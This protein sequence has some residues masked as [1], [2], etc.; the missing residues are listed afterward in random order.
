[1]EPNDAVHHLTEAITAYM[2]WVDNVLRA[3]TDTKR[4]RRT[5][6]MLIARQTVMDRLADLN[7]ATRRRP[8]APR[9]GTS[10]I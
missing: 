7:E 2:G 6:R 10:R 8:R 4:E 9:A 1:M 5:R 3:D